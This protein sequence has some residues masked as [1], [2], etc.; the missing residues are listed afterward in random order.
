VFTL[1]LQGNGHGTQKT[2]YVIVTSLAAWRADCCLATSNNFRNS[3]VACLYSVARCLSIC[4]LAIEGTCSWLRHY[5]TSRKV[6]GSNPDGVD[7]FN[8]PNPSS[9]TMA[10]GLT[11][12]L[13]EMSTRNIPGGKGRP[14]R[15]ADN[16][17]AICEL[18]V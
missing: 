10:L 4:C 18:I 13:T 14:V 15:K 8:L 3:I 6:T 2:S 17:T 11:Q 16:L 7:F 5:A 9:R 12:P 1:S